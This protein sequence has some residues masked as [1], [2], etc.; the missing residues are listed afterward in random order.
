MSQLLQDV[1]YACRT[2]RRSPGLVVTAVLS[3]G[4]GIAAAWAGTRAL[5]GVL[6]GTSPTDPTVFA[7]VVVTLAVVAS[8]ASYLPARRAAR[9]DPIAVLRNS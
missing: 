1:G 3:L 7:A 8:V 5:Q 6:F 4:L 2:L 9:V